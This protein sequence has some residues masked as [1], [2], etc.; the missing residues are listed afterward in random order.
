MGK[1][2]LT[3]IVLGVTAVFAS[4][5]E[6]E[7]QSR[8]RAAPERTPAPNFRAPDPVY[9][10][11]WRTPGAFSAAP[12]YGGVISAPRTNEWGNFGGPST[13]GGGGGGSP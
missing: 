2:L 6:A 1:M 13:G 8:R 12:G 4:G 11:G 3:T 10:Q 9:T 7:A 5:L